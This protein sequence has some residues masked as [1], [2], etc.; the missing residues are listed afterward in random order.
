MR[1]GKM[2][3]L[4]LA[5]TAMVMV[6]P[7][8]FAQADNAR[9]FDMPSQGLGDALRAVAQQSGIQIIAPTELVA[10]HQARAL[11]G[12]YRADQAVS[13]LL[14]GSRLR[15][16]MVGTTLVVQR[17]DVGQEGN[18]TAEGEGEI[19]VTGTRIRGQAP[20]GVS[21][22]TL[23]RSDI[24]KGG[25]STT[26]Q[27]VQSIP[28]NYSGGANE[29]TSGLL[30]AA[31]NGNVSRGSGVNLRGLGATSTLVLINGDRPPL[32]GVSGTFADISV[33]P[34]SIIERVEVVPDGSSAIYGS[35]AVAGVVN[36]VPRLKFDG[37]ETSFRIG[38]ADG[39]F[40]EYQFSQL[41]GTGWSS[42]HVVVAYEYYQ[43]GR[44][45]AADRA[46]AT[47]DLR[48]FGGPDRRS[49]YSNPGTI[50]AGGQ[51]FAI[52]FGQDGRGLTAARLTAGTVNRGNAFY[53]VDL[54]PEQRR[55]SAFFALTQ[56]I[57]PNLRLYAHGL[58]TWRNFDQ[59][60]ATN[61]PARRTVPVTNP[62]YVDPIGTRQPVGV[63]YSFTRDLG[64]ETYRGQVRAF[65]GTAGLEATFGRWTIDAHGS[66]GKQSENYSLLNRV[67]TARLA[68]ALADTNPA[69][70]YNLFGDGP[71]TNPATIES[72][73]GY[74]N[75]SYDGIVWA[76]TL[77]ADGPL[78]ALP[79]GDVRLAVGGEYRED[80]YRDFG[81]T[82]YVSSLTPTRFAPAPL[83]GTRTVKGVYAELLVPVFGED[84]RIPLFRRL[85]L[86]AAIRAEEYSDFGRTTNPKLGL[87]WEPLDGIKLRG[88][89]GKSFR[90]PIFDELRQD[91]DSIGYFAYPAPDPRSST[92]TSN[93]LVLRGNDPNLTPERATT[94]TVGLD[95]TPAAL[96]GLHFGMTWFN[97][98]YRDRIGS[99]A[100]RINSFL[101]DR[102]VY[103]PVTEVNPS[104]ARVNQI[105]DSP[106]YL[107]LTGIPRTAPFVAV[108][109]ARL[110]NLSVVKQSG[111]DFDIGYGF[112]L[113]GGRAEIGA[114]ATYIFRIDQQLTETSRA[115]DVVDMVGS[116]IDLRARAHAG[117]SKNGFS[118]NLF[119]NYADGYRNETVTPIAR[120]SSWTTFD[121]TIGYEFGADR[122]PLR[123]LRVALNG[124]N[125]FDRDPPFVSYLIGTTTYG[126]DGENA[127][128]YGR[129][130][131][132]QVTK[133]W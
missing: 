82:T 42:G 33:I 27:I 99:V 28:Q 90:A 25:F 124:S 115:V 76:G 13:Q 81:G 71:A 129:V 104:P 64:N 30:T 29:T 61:S 68:L 11:R 102:D 26:Q 50:V 40:A 18:E 31:G 52:P 87:S 4:A 57:S 19:L 96:P 107:D 59:A 77:R 70:A 95:L 35:D 101:V 88:S 131:S 75:R 62:F 127:T 109:D 8:A 118:A 105:F 86:S 126:Y 48:P 93:I 128:P 114:V 132:L 39:A 113:G 121:L 41:L 117:W 97:V 45:R 125:I 56:D 65:T 119:M 108:V 14:R 10:G 112:D 83:P 43:R 60:L 89:F 80:R 37:A 123:G 46:Y 100:T 15:V 74:S 120:V 78:F 21:V 79:A 54:V 58:A 23:D 130:V 44:L 36:I 111:L 34:A 17:D 51:T 116:P 66:W 133:K 122:G 22:I 1:M 6:A 63:N 84:A 94:W 32:G 38:T 24:T 12:R 69:T 73:R 3:A 49:I 85:D 20:V 5:G 106:Y 55:H 7:V 92:G 98:D 103:A 67:N 91:P 72:I 9:E 53:G 16:V 47:E 110:T 2:G